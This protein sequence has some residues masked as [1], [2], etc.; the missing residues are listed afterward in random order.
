MF[1]GPPL[2]RHPEA[3]IRAAQLGLRRGPAH[4]GRETQWPA[5]SKL[6]YGLAEATAAIS[7]PSGTPQPKTAALG[8]WIALK[9]LPAYVVLEAAGMSQQLFGE[10]CAAAESTR[11]FHY[12]EAVDSAAVTERRATASLAPKDP[13]PSAAVAGTPSPVGDSEAIG[14]AVGDTAIHSAAV[15]A[16][17]RDRMSNDSGLSSTLPEASSPHM[18]LEHNP[19]GR[20]LHSGF[21]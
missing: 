8:P 4:L 12:P 19:K 15:L 11:A 18:H 5:G 6:R 21:P 7:H 3:C 9:P 13:S 16:A 10:A 17:V 20:D 2:R 14:A 1:S